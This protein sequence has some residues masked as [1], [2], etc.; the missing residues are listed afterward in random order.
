MNVLIFIEMFFLQ[1]D[2]GML[3]APVPQPPELFFRTLWIYPVLLSVLSLL[4]LYIGYKGVYRLTA[5]R[6]QAWREKTTQSPKT[7]HPVYGY[8]L[9]DSLGLVCSLASMNLHIYSLE[10]SVGSVV[11]IVALNVVNIGLFVLSTLLMPRK[12]RLIEEDYQKTMREIDAEEMAEGK[13]IEGGPET[14][15]ETAR[16]PYYLVDLVL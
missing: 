10:Y 16:I 4:A 14:P 8:L 7:M 13:E 12:R 6:I 3:S 15:A 5:D 1:R 9:L 2:I 11:A